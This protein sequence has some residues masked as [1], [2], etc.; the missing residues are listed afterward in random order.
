MKILALD[1]GASTV[2]L[3][4]LSPA[5]LRTA[6]MMRTGLAAE[7]ELLAAISH[8]AGEGSLSSLDEIRIGSTGAI[9]MLL[10]RGGARVGLIATNGF[11]DTL[12]LA[13]QNRADLYDPVARSPA[14]LF[15]VAPGAIHEVAGR[16][17]PRGMELE[18]LAQA[19]IR[20]AGEKLRRQGVEAIAVCFLFAHLNPAHERACAAVLAEVAPGIPVILSHQVDGNAREYERTVSACLEAALR[21]SQLAT[22]TRIEAGLRAH[23]F[24]GRLSFADSRGYLVAPEAAQACVTRQLVGGPAASAL[25]AAALVRELPD[26]RALAI[27][28]G[29]TSTDIVLIDNSAPATTTH[30]TVA[31]VPLRIPMADIHSVAIGGGARLVAVRP[32]ISLSGAAPADAPSVTDA[33]VALGVLPRALGPGAAERLAGPAMELATDSAGLAAMIR[34]AALDDIA[35]SILR[36][37]VSRNVDPAS[38]PLVAGGGL[39]QAIGCAVAERLGT[40]QVVI[41][42]HAAVAGAIGLLAARHVREAV[43]TVNAPLDGL[44]DAMLAAMLDC[45]AASDQRADGGTLVLTIAPNAFMHPV[46]LHLAQTI[47]TVA[48]LRDAFTAY[49]VAR[50]GTAAAETGFVFSIGRLLLE[51]PQNRPDEA[52]TQPPLIA[53]EGWDAQEGNGVTILTRRGTETVLRPETLQMR[54]NAI[55]QSMQEILFRTAVSPVVREGNDAAAA[56]LTP[57]GEL[58]ALSDAIPLLLG[59]LDGAAR[60]LLA[61]FPRETMRDGDLYLMNDPF[62]GGTHLP[63]L[64]VMRPIF[65]AG[66]LIAFAAS[67]LHH[68]DIG[69]MRPGSVPP[70]AVDIFQEGLRLPP[71]K[72]GADGRIDRHVIDLIEANSRAPATVLGDLTSQ[73][74]AAAQ[75]AAALRSLVRETGVAAFLGGAGKCLDRGEAAARAAVAMMAPGPHRAT[76]RLDPTQGLPE[77]RIELAL[78]CADGRFRADFTGTTEQVAAP[79]NCVRSGPFAASFYSLLSAMGPT[80]FRNG[81]VV[82]VIDLVLP[83]E[84]AINAAPPAAV[85]ARMGI[86]R[87]TTSSLLQALAKALPARMPAANSGM[88]YVL[89]FSGMGEDGKRFIVTEIIAGGAGGGPQADGASGISTDVGNAMNMPAEALESQIPVRLVSAVI[90]SGSGGAGRFRGGDGIRRTYLALRDGINVSLRGERFCYVPQG[91]LGGG[92]PLPAAAHVVRADG[93]VETLK[94]RSTPVLNAGDRL[95]VESCGGA[96]YGVSGEAVRS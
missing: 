92:S 6:K 95:V 89:A 50:F 35:A 84:C 7:D 10:A 23:G 42:P 66:T 77:I 17:D 76:E 38:V 36:Y 87:A 24:T 62:L 71:M 58:I 86:V 2:D 40:Q 33:L 80:V 37:A 73:I 96:G 31:G 18:P 22:L 61:R 15:L 78:T 75:A 55:A 64:T 54:L 1:I 29:S 21:P 79:I 81:G 48:D 63:D 34:D 68:Q 90:R 16:L 67:I 44:D 9:N 4:L 13:R 88:S 91:L 83:E 26:G 52:S 82:R 60:A 28:A 72:M 25:A 5:G 41:G 3:A 32:A 47:P 46:T 51:P 57:D 12:A 49:H 70:D 8:G 39:G 14:P 19:Q 20:A 30:G 74:G 45:L 53:P 69:G 27:D 56:L 65:E 59:A 43:T 85:N 93:R 94:T 11:G